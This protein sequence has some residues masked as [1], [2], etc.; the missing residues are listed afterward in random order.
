MVETVLAYYDGHVWILVNELIKRGIKIKDSSKLKRFFVINSEEALDEA[1]GIARYS[2]HVN[3][4]CMLTNSYRPT[5]DR[6]NKVLS[7]FPNLGLLACSEYTWLRRLR[8]SL[9]SLFHV[10]SM[11]RGGLR[12]WTPEVVRFVR[13]RLWY[14]DRL[15]TICRMLN[16]FEIKISVKGFLKFRWRQV[17]P[18]I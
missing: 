17:R 4:N 5:W 11:P 1:C 2:P 9:S 15:G 3:F 12:K 16:L 6:F 14:G 18:F 10:L 13:D 7:M 8:A